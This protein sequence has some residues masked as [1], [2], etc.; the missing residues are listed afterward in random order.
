MPLAAPVLWVTPSDPD[1]PQR[2][3]DRVAEH[4]AG[5]AVLVLKPLEVWRLKKRDP[6][7]LDAEVDAVAEFAESRGRAHVFGFSAGATVALA[8]GLALRQSV[9]SV[10]VCEPATIGDDDWSPI[11]SEWRGRMDLICS[12][13]PRSARPRAFAAAMLPEGRAVPP[14]RL[15]PP[16]WDQRRDR[17]E[18]ALRSVGF[19]SQDLESL[20][21]PCLVLTGADSHERFQRVADRLAEVIPRGRTV[22]YPGTSHLAPPMRERPSQVAADLWAFWNEAEHAGPAAAR[23]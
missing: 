3:F 13:Q 4:L 1:G 9:A 6:Y 21:Q 16:G 5:Q 15:Q 8:A 2:S 11:E 10:A 14:S 18:G 23:T 7:D 17:L 22:N 12:L 20:T 19:A